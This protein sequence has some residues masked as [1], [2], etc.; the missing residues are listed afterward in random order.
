MKAILVKDIYRNTEEY[1]DKTITIS[2]WVRTL[3]ASKA[4]GFIE[5][6]DG[7]FFKN[8]QVVFEEN[9]ENFK[10]ISKFTIASAVVVEG[11]LVATPG[12][13]QPFEIKATKITLEADSD[14]DYP[15]QKKRHTFEYFKALFPMK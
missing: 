1:V 5:L 2:G 15:L 3:R 13:K 9:L 12:A 10:E 7:S 14:R 4:F 11:T 8:I 6:N